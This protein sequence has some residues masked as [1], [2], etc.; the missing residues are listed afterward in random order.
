[1]EEIKRSQKWGTFVRNGVVVSN[2]ARTGGVREIHLERQQAVEDGF[3]LMRRVV[4]GLNSAVL[5]VV[6][7]LS[8][9]VPV[10]QRYP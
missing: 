8:P 4:Q 1:M 7:D 10:Y 5:Q 3:I 6:K 2:V 9:D